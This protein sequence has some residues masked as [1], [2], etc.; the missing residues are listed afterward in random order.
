MNSVDSTS[1]IPHGQRKSHGSVWI[2]SHVEKLSEIIPT[3]LEIVP[4]A[5]G[6]QIKPVTA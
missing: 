1:H 5:E 6:N 4:S 2:I 3:R